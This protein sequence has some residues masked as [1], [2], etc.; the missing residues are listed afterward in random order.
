MYLYLQWLSA[1]EEVTRL[2]K[3]A[4]RRIRGKVTEAVRAVERSSERLGQGVEDVA[5][6]PEFTT[7]LETMRDSIIAIKVSQA[8]TPRVAGQPAPWT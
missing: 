6:V 3:V 1:L 7:P 8:A 4:R 5:L 2:R